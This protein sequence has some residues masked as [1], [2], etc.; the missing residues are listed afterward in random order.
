[1]YVCLLVNVDELLYLV[2]EC[3]MSWDQ[4]REV[5][6]QGIRA[7][8]INDKIKKKQMIQTFTSEMDELLPPADV[9]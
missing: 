7:S 8:F 1:M 6:L 4:V 3:K 9:Q 5:L 2:C